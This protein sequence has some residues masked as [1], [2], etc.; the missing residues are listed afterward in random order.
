M[1]VAEYHAKGFTVLRNAIQFGWPDGTVD[2]LYN[3]WRRL[4]RE[5]YLRAARLQAK[6]IGLMG[7]FLSP[8]IQRAVSQLGIQEPVMLTNP[9]VHVMG[10]DPHWDGVAAHQ[11]YTAL[12]S[13]LNTVVVWLP[14]TDVTLEN[15]PIEFASGSHL[16]GLMPAKPGAH[17]SEVDTTGLEFEPVPVKAGDAILF[18]VFTLHRTRTPGNGFRLAFSHRYEDAADP[19]FKE[20]LNYSAQRTVIEREVRN[21]PTREQ[22]QEVFKYA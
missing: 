10:V 9:A 17:Y 20:H 16:E 5:E 1:N 15:Y 8:A 13:S 18:S 3:A 7:M 2:L 14:F 4:P 21:A 12:Q 22:V 6:G 19:W 11:D